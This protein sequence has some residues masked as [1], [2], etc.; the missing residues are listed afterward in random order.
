MRLFPALFLMV[1]A[2]LYSVACSAGEPA[3]VPMLS[4]QGFTGILNTPNAHVSNEG[5][6][7]LMYTDQREN[8]WRND[9]RKDRQ[10]HQEN[11]LL[12]VGLF[13][14]FEV[15][16][17]LAEAPGR[18]RDL[19]ASLKVTSAP[20]TKEQAFWPVLAVGIQDIGGGANKLKSTYAVISEDF[21]R[22]RFSAGYGFSSERMK[23]GFGGVEFQAHDWVTLLGEY[24]T[25]DTSAGLRLTSPTLPWFPANL[26]FT[27]K[28]ALNHTSG[29]DLAFGLTVPLD[30]KKSVTASTRQVP[31]PEQQT[32]DVSE[33]VDKPA[34]RQPA[35]QH[36]SINAPDRQL[37][38]D[39]RSPSETQNSRLTA[40]HSQLSSIRT[41]LIDA[42]FAN[43]R[44]GEVADTVLVVE[45][46]NVR[47]NHNELDAIGVVAGIACSVDLAGVDTLWLVVKRKGLRIIRLSTPFKEMRNWLTDGGAAQVPAIR[48]ENDTSQVETA[49]FIDGDSNPDWLRPSLIIFPGLKTFI[50][51]E[52][53][54]FDYLLSVK[55]DLQVTV[56]K[57]GVLNARWDL[58]V[59]WSD[60]F[61]NRRQFANSRNQPLM[62]RLMLFQGISLAPG[63]IANLGGGMI[64]H[65]NYGTLN[66]LTWSP[67]SG[68]H[69]FRLAQAYARDSD[70]RTTTRVWLGSYRMYLAPLDLFLEGT[71]GRFW[72][73]DTG[74]HV[75]LK[76]FFGDTA[77]ELYY[78][79]T[80]TTEQKRWQAAGLQFSF[81][82]TPRRDMQRA[83]L[84][85]RGADEWGYAQETVLA[86]N[87]Q[88]TNDTISS[89]LGINPL[90][91]AD[92]YRSY[93]NRDR[94]NE[95]YIL[96]HKQRIKE[97]WQTFRDSLSEALPRF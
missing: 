97:A 47:Y 67:G 14:F 55:P 20:L 13:S 40:K 15:G 86:I 10:K 39:S 81:P 56:W 17:R 38:E 24:D 25:R 49:S 74:G 3:Q 30:L 61:D 26:T 16:G 75:A 36:P 59:A 83:P 91:S 93:L 19:S 23:G 58:P 48:V 44:V 4:Y 65:D 11:Y 31:E 34:T 18:A 57:G 78:K 94:L 82:L 87:G 50:G 51:T 77:V 60:N 64:L 2:M 92:I 69:R 95:D 85:V 52:V 29:L 88:R 62:D 9:L 68:T 45:Y 42:G 79:N 73:Q 70:S 37:P 22:L 46:E 27:A 12:S 80:E 76:R 28:S 96:T 53:G 35:T 71:V 7:H 89:A 43:V 32:R 1:L 6:L 5:S 72:G 21:W 84:Q 54:V 66:E 63:L 8:I 41:R 90:P 33:T